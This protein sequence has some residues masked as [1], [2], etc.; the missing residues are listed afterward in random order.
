MGLLRHIQPTAMIGS[1]PPPEEPPAS[2]WAVRQ[3][4]MRERAVSVCR[5]PAPADAGIRRGRPRR[6]PRWPPGRRSLDR[7]APWPGA[8]RCGRFITP[9]RGAASEGAL[10]AS[11]IPAMASPLPVRSYTR[12]TTAMAETPLP[13]REMPWPVQRAQKGRLRARLRLACVSASRARGV[14]RAQRNV[15]AYYTLKLRSD[16]PHAPFG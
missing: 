10:R 16:P 3:L 15:V 5:S 8:G 6:R 1:R 14:C 11:R 12:M 9:A 13:R 7:S 4:K 2:G